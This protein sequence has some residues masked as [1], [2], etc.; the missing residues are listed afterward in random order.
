[1]ND[2]FSYSTIRYLDK[3]YHNLDIVPLEE[4]QDY[5]VCIVNAKKLDPIQEHILFH[6]MIDVSGS[7]S[8]VT[9]RGRTKMQLLIHTLRNMIRYFSNNHENIHI[10]VKGFD[11]RI[12]NVINKTHITK[13][14]FVELSNLL[15]DVVPLGCTDIYNALMTMKNDMHT[16]RHMRQVGIFLTDGEITQGE[17]SPDKLAELIPSNIPFHFIAL[18]HD[19]NA[20]VM[21]RLGHC[22]HVTNNWFINELEQTGNIY[23]EILYNELHKVLEN[24]S[25]KI[26]NGV[27]FDYYSQEFVEELFLGSISGET[28]KHYHV[29]SH[30]T[31]NCVV[32]IKGTLPGSQEEYVHEI[33]EIPP[34]IPSDDATIEFLY[35][36]PFFM[37]IQFC[38]LV[39]QVY[40]GKARMKFQNQQPEHHDIFTRVGRTGASILEVA[41]FRER[42]KN[43]L[44]FLNQFIDTNHLGENEWT[45]ILCD[46]LA[47]LLQTLGGN[48]VLKYC[49]LREDNQGQQR[50]SNSVS[51][52]HEED[53]SRDESIAD[54]PVL[55]RNPTTPFRT[56]GRMNLMNSLSQDREDIRE[57]LFIETDFDE[58]S[59]E[60]YLTPT[61]LRNV[62]S[63]E[64]ANVNP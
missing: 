51:F 56:P 42:I 9:E 45:R 54:L 18:G 35:K 13:D 58:E 47:I 21:H 50:V 5:G 16:H 61:I 8:D 31:D 22:T 63:F 48:A 33:S 59:Q 19:H 30:D 57:R 60:P 41:N 1:M 64:N 55:S 40:L 38:R 52:V 27:L 2:C 53:Q 49:G 28:E 32:Q 34:L 26:E 44:A 24:V 43:Y 20:S 12:H 3:P 39:T 25:L 36:S 14:N 23:G 29:I 37:E 17:N 4:N 7:M 15:H 6:F 62:D 46:D 10:I 11:D